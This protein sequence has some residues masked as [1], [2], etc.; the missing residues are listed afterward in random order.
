M[1][2]K[3]VLLLSDTHIGSTVGL[4]PNEFKSQSGHPLPPSVFQDWLLDCWED[5][6]LSVM[7]K[8]AELSG[9]SPPELTTVFNGDVI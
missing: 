1:T 6:Q 7:L 3:F 5:M 9:D 4:W 8:L 2:K